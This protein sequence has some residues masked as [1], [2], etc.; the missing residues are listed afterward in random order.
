MATKTKLN[1]TVSFLLKFIV[2]KVYL[3]LLFAYTHKKKDVLLCR[4]LGFSIP[5]NEKGKRCDA[6]AVPATVSATLR[7]SLSHCVPGAWEGNCEA[8]ARRP[9]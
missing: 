5:E 4:L 2:T 6:F 3:F 7:N 8:Q 9:A 1:K